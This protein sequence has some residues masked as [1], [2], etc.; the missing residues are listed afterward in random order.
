M[1]VQGEVSCNV[2]VVGAASRPWNPFSWTGSNWENA[3]DIF[4]AQF[5]TPNVRLQVCVCVCVWL[6]GGQRSTNSHEM[7]SPHQG[8]QR[9][10]KSN[11]K[12]FLLQKGGEMVLSELP[13]H[14]NLH[15]AWPEQV[16]GSSGFSL[17][18]ASK[19][20]AWKYFHEYGPHRRQLVSLHRR[21]G[22]IVAIQCD[23]YDGF[24]A[25]EGVYFKVIVATAFE[26]WCQQWTSVDAIVAQASPG[27]R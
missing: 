3:S 5:G 21:A 27:E 25:N 4:R 17:K 16:Q 14:S 7:D 15:R 9:R 10:S 20:G 26:I 2:S 11:K 23:A 1:E 18:A 24:F 13:S 22:S 8:A 19:A 12:V 6:Y